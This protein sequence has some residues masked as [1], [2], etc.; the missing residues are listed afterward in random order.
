LK[1]T[2]APL[3]E[4]LFICRTSLSLKGTL[5]SMR[6]IF[7]EGSDDFCFGNYGGGGGGEEV[8]NMMEVVVMKRWT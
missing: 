4:L 7:I 6:M 5:D 3:P 1:A 2:S 8:E